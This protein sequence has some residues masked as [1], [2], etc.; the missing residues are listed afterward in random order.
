M[1]YVHLFLR[2]YDGGWCGVIAHHGTVLYETDTVS[3][4]VAAEARGRTWAR[5]HGYRICWIA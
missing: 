4:A 5:E 1:T 2:R 3:S